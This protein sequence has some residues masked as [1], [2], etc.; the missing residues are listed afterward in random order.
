MT[1]VA[2]PI[3]AQE[4]RFILQLIFQ[5]VVGFLVASG[6]VDPGIKDAL[7]IQLVDFVGL[8]IIA[9]TSGIGLFRLGKLAVHTTHPTTQQTSSIVTST[10]VSTPTDP[11]KSDIFTEVID[12]GTPLSIPPADEQVLSPDQKI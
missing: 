6:Y 2:N 7:I 9:I 11:V 3:V 8:L 1:P 12:G 5:Y 4:L 10:T